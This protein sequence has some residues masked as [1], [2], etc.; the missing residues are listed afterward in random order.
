MHFLLRGSPCQEIPVLAESHLLPHSAVGECC[1]LV[2]HSL[3]QASVEY[4]ESDAIGSIIMQHQFKLVV[5]I[6]DS[7]LWVKQQLEQ[8][9]K[10]QLKQ[11]LKLQVGLQL[12]QQLEK[13]LKQKTCSKVLLSTVLY[14]ICFAV[15]F[16]FSWYF[17][18]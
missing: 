16:F 10:G 17:S 3:A 4:S 1:R 18:H 13:L 5:I 6:I 2:F 7:L 15:F 11:Q 12:V 8:R 14:S 9:L